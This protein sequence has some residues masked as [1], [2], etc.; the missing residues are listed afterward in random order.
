MKGLDSPF[1]VE[2]I[3][4]LKQGGEGEEWGEWGGGRVGNATRSRARRARL[5]CARTMTATNGNGTR[6]WLSQITVFQIPT[7]Y[8]RLMVD[9]LMTGCMSDEL[10]MKEPEP[11]DLWVLKTV[12]KL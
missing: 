12:R 4:L 5:F 1:P 6:V 3:Y 2:V 10:S 9:S 8:P 11:L 7:V